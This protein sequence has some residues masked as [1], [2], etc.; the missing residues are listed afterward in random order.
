VRHGTLL[1]PRAVLETSGIHA[2][3]MDCDFLTFPFFSYVTGRVRSSV[4]EAHAPTDQMSSGCFLPPHLHSADV[5]L[6]STSPPEDAQPASAVFKQNHDW[7][8]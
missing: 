1:P 6:A 5:N 4:L 8:D 2:Q 3:L 7:L